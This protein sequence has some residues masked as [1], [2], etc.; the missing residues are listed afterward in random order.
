MSLRTMLCMCVGGGRKMSSQTSPSVMDG[1][2]AHSGLP[3]TA[4]EGWNVGGS[5]ADGLRAVATLTM[6]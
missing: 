3:P 6:T 1:S 5:P 4:I 2:K